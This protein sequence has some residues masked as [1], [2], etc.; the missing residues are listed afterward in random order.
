MTEYYRP[1]YTP[2]WFDLKNYEPL[3]DMDR[4]EIWATICTLSSVYDDLPNGSEIIIPGECDEPDDIFECYPSGFL[5]ML[6]RGEPIKKPQNAHIAPE[7]SI[8]PLTMADYFLIA[9]TVRTDR[10]KHYKETGARRCT[11]I[12]PLVKG[13]PPVI[14]VQFFQ[15]DKKIL[16]DFEAW[17]KEQRKQYKPISQKKRLSDDGLKKLI[18]DRIVPCMHLLIWGVAKDIHYTDAELKAMIFPDGACSSDRQ[19]GRYKKTALNYLENLL[20]AFHIL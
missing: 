3:K 8:T 4:R 14:T 15:D 6:E 18:R 7:S 10:Y 20:D 2:E 9:E 5:E 16:S 17:L 11:D 19:M 13:S 12:I 1:D